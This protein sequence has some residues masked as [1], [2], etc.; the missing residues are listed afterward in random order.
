MKE[1]KKVWIKSFVFLAQPCFFI[2]SL[3]LDKPYKI[4]EFQLQNET[5]QRL[6]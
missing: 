4:S 1:S 6:S 3:I 2:I 5:I